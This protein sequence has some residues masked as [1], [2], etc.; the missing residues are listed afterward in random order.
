[1]PPLI[2]DVRSAAFVQRHCALSAFWHS[3]RRGPVSSLRI[4]GLPSSKA[5]HFENTCTA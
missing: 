5:A 3:R 4:V 1:V 2:Q